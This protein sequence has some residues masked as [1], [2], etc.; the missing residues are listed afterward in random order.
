MI[1]SI[2]NDKKNIHYEQDVKVYPSGHQVCCFG[3]LGCWWRICPDELKEERGVR[4]EEREYFSNHKV[5]RN[6]MN[7]IR[8]QSL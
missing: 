5:Q 7:R 8:D 6:I 3:P 2:H 1:I 4:K